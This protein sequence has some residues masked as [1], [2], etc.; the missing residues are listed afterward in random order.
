MLGL[1][2]VFYLVFLGI[3]LRWLRLGQSKWLAWAGTLT[4]PVYLL[5]HNMGY[6]VFQRVGNSINRYVL[7]AAMMVALLVLAY[8]LHVLMERRYANRFGQWL[9]G[10]LARA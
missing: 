6:I 9:R 1:I 5:H 7:L 2:T 3:V 8:L 10:Q 4:Y